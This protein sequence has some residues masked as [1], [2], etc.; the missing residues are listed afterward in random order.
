ML[1]GLVGVGKSLSNLQKISYCWAR[2]F[3]IIGKELTGNIIRHFYKVLIFCICCQ[4]PVS[5]GSIFQD[6]MNIIDPV[7]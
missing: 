5:P 7:S 4:L 3:L 2:S 1:N 6:L